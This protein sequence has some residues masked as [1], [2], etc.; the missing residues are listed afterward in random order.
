MKNK[1]ISVLIMLVAGAA[2]SIVFLIQRIDPTIMLL[3]LIIIL[4]VFYIFGRIV[5]K[6]I[7]NL[8]KE[9]INKERLEAERIKQIV[10]SKII[11][12]ENSVEDKL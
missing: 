2:S 9:V 3:N 7:L 11:E 8:N 10:V 1:W 4:P 5:E 12:E 6:I